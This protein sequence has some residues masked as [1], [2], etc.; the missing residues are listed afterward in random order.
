MQMTY[1]GAPPISI[2]PRFAAKTIEQCIQDDPVCS[3]GGENT[4]AHGMYIAD[5]LT[6]Q[7]ADFVVNKLP[8]GGSG[9]PPEQVASPG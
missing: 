8:R 4:G 6:D 7:A 9:R 5:G 2:G 3:P 1:S